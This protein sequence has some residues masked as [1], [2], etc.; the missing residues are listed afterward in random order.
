DGFE[1]L[2]FPDRT[3]PLS[4]E[5][6]RGILPL[7]GT[8]LGTSNRCNPFALRVREADTVRTEDRSEQVLE[9]ARALELDVLV[10]IGGDGSVR[11]GHQLHEL[12]LP[13]AGVPKTIDNHLP[14]TDVTFGSD[15]A[16]NTASEAIDKLHTTAESHH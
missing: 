10:V 11:I 9:T 6:V 13:V 3:R 7:G 4:A 8:I 12:G 15:T 16:L 14:A 5:D 2:L 1:G